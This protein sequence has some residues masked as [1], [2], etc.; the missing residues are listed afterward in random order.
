MTSVGVRQAVYGVLAGDT[1]LAGLGYGPAGIYPNFSPD[2]P[3]ERLFIVLRWGPITPGVGGAHSGDLGVWAYNRDED[4]GPIEAALQRVRVLL[5]PFPGTRIPSGG[6][7]LGV[8]WGG[9]GAD[10]FDDAYQAWT[11]PENYT[12]TESGN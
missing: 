8:D 12:I 11:R 9:T 10:L 4:Y 2:T 3:A 5:E 7:F 6:A 1:V